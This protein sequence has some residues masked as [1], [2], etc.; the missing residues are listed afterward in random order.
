MPDADET[1]S[2][3]EPRED[4]PA[5]EAAPAESPEP[6]GSGSGTTDSSAPGGEGSE[7]D[8]SLGEATAVEDGSESEQPAGIE[9]VF[10]PDPVLAASVDVARAALAEITPAE[11][12][13]DLV[14]TVAQGEHVL[15]LQFANRMRGYPGWLW[16]ATLSRIDETEGVAVLEVE[17]LPGEGAVLAPD[18]VPWSVRLAD[19]H[20]AQEA[21]GEEVDDETDDLDED[22][23]DDSA[24]EDDDSDLEGDLDDDAGLEGDDPED[25]AEDDEGEDSAD[26]SPE[27]SDDDSRTGAREVAAPTR[28]R[29]RRR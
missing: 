28:R 15:S 22:D 18:W 25:D 5:S 12:I 11:T 23:L 2:G 9:P 4:A 14:D 17:L 8:A 13:G 20:A 24:D 10:E 7:A 1:T 16:T 19:Y 21:A 3:Q 27:Y 26:D 29:R 6:A